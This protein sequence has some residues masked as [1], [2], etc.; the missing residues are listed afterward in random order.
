MFHSII[1]IFCASIESHHKLECSQMKAF[2]RNFPLV[3]MQTWEQRFHA[4]GTFRNADH[5]IRPHV[6]MDATPSRTL[7]WTRRHCERCHGR[8]IIA[9]V[10]M[11]A[12][13]SQHIIM[14]KQKLRVE[15]ICYAL[16]FCP[17]L[18]F[19]DYIQIKLIL[20][21]IISSQKQ[22]IFC[23]LSLKIFISCKINSL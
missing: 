6:A 7:P 9:N 15:I 13:S 16:F 1:I 21:T 5:V 14:N 17:L 3:C 11:D 23:G 10:A 8:D 2:C 20:F 12:T 4:L 22:I 18:S 19:L